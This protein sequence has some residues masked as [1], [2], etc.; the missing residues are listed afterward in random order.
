MPCQVTILHGWSDHSDSFQPLAAFLR[1]HG[2]DVVPIW[3]G[4]YRSTDDDVRIEDVA[5]RMDLVVRSMLADGRLQRPFDMVVHSTG[6]LVARQWLTAHCPD[7]D[8]YP[9]RRLLMLAPANFGSRL[10]DMGESLLG[11][12]VKGWDNWFQTG[13]QMLAALELGSAFQWDLAQRDLF[14]PEGQAGA[15][16][17]YGENAVWPFV[18]TGTHPY[19]DLLRRIVN[20]HG[21]DGTVRVAA[22]NLNAKGVTVDFS[23][24]DARPEARPWV[25][26][27]GELAFPFAVLPDRNHFLITRPDLPGA[28]GGPD[29]LG[30]SILAALACG[31]FAEYRQLADSWAATGRATAA[32]AADPAAR[33]A[34]F[35]DGAPDP[36]SFHQYLQLVVRVEDDQGLRV[37]DYFL[38]FFSPGEPPG[39]ETTD[40]SVYFH[41]EVLKHVHVGGDEPSRRCLYLDHTDLEGPY[42]ALVA[43]PAV[44]ALVMSLSAAAPGPNVRYFA[45]SQ[46][47][48]V[49]HV[50]VHDQAG[51]ARWLEPNRTHLA[52]VIIPRH[53]D[54]GV[55]TLKRA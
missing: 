32:L 37:G 36:E 35:P 28:G 5:Q 16:G 30:P 43:A 39:A 2:Y 34:Q 52:R 18:L 40:D 14:V 21:S 47:G 8:G 54:E 13:K 46:A 23:R 12:V 24:D 11:R 38:E 9:V 26:R 45:N 42:Y 25:A 44:K 51:G 50:R 15:A 53:P 10:A 7:Q 41:R 4:D 22:A 19:T 55:F 3:L 6:G 27:H 20:E 33:S 29:A 31:T 48:A 1:G 17:P 49:G